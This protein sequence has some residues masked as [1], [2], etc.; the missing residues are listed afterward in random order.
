MSGRIAKRRQSPKSS[1][2]LS[3]RK[4]SAR[5]STLTARE[6]AAY[7]RTANLVSDLRAGRGPYSKLL[8][9]HH[10]HTRTAAWGGP[11]FAY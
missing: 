2:R 8:R 9:K 11:R 4:P 10:L 6:K 1:Q 7:E 5:Y 3:T